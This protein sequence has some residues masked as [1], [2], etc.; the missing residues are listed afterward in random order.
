MVILPGLGNSGADYDDLVVDL[1]SHGI[2]AHT[3]PVERYDWLRN[4]A[5]LRYL[6]YWQGKLAPRPTVDW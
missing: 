3:V 4:A 2:N 1:G 6:E 5:G